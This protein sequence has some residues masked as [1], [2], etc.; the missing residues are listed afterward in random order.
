MANPSLL[1]L[2]IPFIF[3][4]CSTGKTETLTTGTYW[5]C[6][7]SRSYCCQRVPWCLALLWFVWNLWF[8]T[9][10]ERAKWW[11]L[12]FV[13]LYFQA[14][15]LAMPPLPFELLPIFKDV[16]G[17]PS[18]TAKPSP[19]EPKAM[20]MTFFPQL[21]QDLGLGCWKEK[22][23]KGLEFLALLW[24]PSEEAKSTPSTGSSL[25]VEYIHG[26]AAQNS[27]C[28]FRFW[29]RGAPLDFSVAPGKA[30]SKERP[31]QQILQTW[32]PYKFPKRS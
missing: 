4:G 31:F 28:Q 19:E 21:F 11:S 12:D 9:G 6:L 16:G 2:L 14:T 23:K 15:P 17:I 3:L 7:L 18:E 8:K 22:M 26:I 32:Q 5:Y 24:S 30:E 29:C 20:V 1:S 10:E 27:G 13:V 25:K